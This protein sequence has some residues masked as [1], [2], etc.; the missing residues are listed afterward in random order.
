MAF[1]YDK[2]NASFYCNYFFCGYIISYSYCN[3]TSFCVF[4]SITFFRLSMI[5][6][7]LIPR[8]LVFCFKLTSDSLDCLEQFDVI[9]NLIKLN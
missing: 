9:W 2:F 3:L 7:R 6:R 1:Y 5:I 8:N 4:T